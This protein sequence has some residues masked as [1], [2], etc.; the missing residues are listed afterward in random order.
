MFS[1]ANVSPSEK[2]GSSR[3]ATLKGMAKLNRDAVSLRVRAVREELRLTP[4]DFAKRLGVGR[5]AYANW[6]AI[7]PKKPNFPSQE[8][9]ATMCELMPGLTMDYIY[10]GNAGK[11]PLNLAIRLLAR[12]KGIDPDRPGFSPAL[13]LP[14]L[15]L[16][17]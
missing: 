14:A 2:T 7:N 8:G 10:L 13:V 11:L 9:I 16:A 15:S 12:E 5:T 6:E 17:D 4:T 1:G 3:F